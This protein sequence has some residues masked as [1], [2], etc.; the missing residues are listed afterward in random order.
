MTPASIVTYSV[1]GVRHNEEGLALAF[2]GDSMGHHLS[3]KGKGMTD[4]KKK[5]GVRLFQLR[6]DARMTQVQLARRVGLS[7][8][9]VRSIERGDASSRM[10][11]LLKLARG[12]RVDPPELLNFRGRE[13]RALAECPSEVLG[14]WNLLRNAKRSH[15]KKVYDIAK[16]LMT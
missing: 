8:D 5:L 4:I 11:S 15:I 9:L 10:E 16:I 14:L 2:E 6:T 1:T 7:V 13:F 3:K 12:L